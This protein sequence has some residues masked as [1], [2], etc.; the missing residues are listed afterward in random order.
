MEYPLHVSFKIA[1]FGNRFTMTDNN[2]NVLFYVKQKMFKLKEAIK[3]FT[4]NT[5]TNQLYTINADRIIDFSARYNFTDMNG[6]SLGSI[7]RKGMRSLWRAN[8]QVFDGDNQLLT[9]KEES[10][11][12]RFMD[13]LFASI[14]CIG[15]CAGFVFH[16]SYLIAKLDG[17]EM[18]RVKKKPALFE[19][20]F[21]IEKLT[22]MSEFE[23]MQ[24]LLSIMMMLLLERVRG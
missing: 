16:P 20:K 22:E 9:I 19:G 6:Q 15:L 4:D 14:P 8:Y 21:K 23:E 13:S 7:K 10:V 18:M 2:E 11:F 3:V 24:M 12:V 5:Q 17:T 1:T